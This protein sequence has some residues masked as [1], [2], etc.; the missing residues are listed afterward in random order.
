MLARHCSSQQALSKHVRAHQSTARQAKVSRPGKPAW[1]RDP[2]AGR[3]PECRSPP[4]TGCEWTPRHAPHRCTSRP[5]SAC[6]LG[7]N[8]CCLVVSQTCRTGLQWTWMPCLEA[9]TSMALRHSGRDNCLTDL[10]CLAVL[11]KQT[12]KVGSI[13]S[14]GDSNGAP[15]SSNAAL[16]VVRHDHGD[17]AIQA[18]SGVHL[19][20]EHIQV[21]QPVRLGRDIVPCA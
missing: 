17:C 1:A 11:A 21:V 14:L 5:S 13:S 8:S 9:S 3:G 10:I 4:P 16:R 19:V 20:L 12:G 18:E 7:L 6:M 2:A 15:E